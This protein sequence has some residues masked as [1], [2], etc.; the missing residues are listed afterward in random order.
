MDAVVEEKR[1]MQKTIR[2]ISHGTAWFKNDSRILELMKFQCSA[3][4]SAYQ[5]IHKHK[6]KDN[7]VKIHLKKNYMEDLNQRYISDSCSMAKGI[8]H[9]SSLF[10]GKKLWDKLIKKTISKEEWQ[11]KRNNRLYSRGDKTKNGN[12]NIRVKNGKIFVNDPSKRGKWIEGKIWMPKK[13]ENLNTEC[14]DVRLIKKNKKYELKISWKEEI[15]SQIKHEKGMIGIDTNP[16]GVAVCD[17]NEEGNLLKHFY[18]QKDRIRYARKGKRDNDIYQIAKKVVDYALERK[19]KISL[20]KL[21]FKKKTKYRKFNRMAHNFAYKKLIESIKSRALKNGIEIKEVNPAFTSNLGQLKYQ[22]MYGL[23]RH[24]AA[25]LVIA[26]RAMNIKERKDFKVEPHEKKK[27]ALNLEGRGTSIAL[28]QKAWSW[29]QTFLKPNSVI[30]TG[31][32]LAA[33]LRSAIGFSVGETPANESIAITGR[34]GKS[35]L[36]DFKF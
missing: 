27:D 34:Y 9:E 15:H 1:K 2:Q 19:K 21:N 33:D 18:I 13:F 35:L 5:A 29:L 6:K 24:T 20:E 11:K 10:G 3:T 14:Y 17:V 31:S 8:I 22:K 7:D 16:D 28:T 36:D 4:R 30:L 25:A 32:N 26:R 23:N 12:P